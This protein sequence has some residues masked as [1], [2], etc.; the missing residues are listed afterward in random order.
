MQ[1]P[2]ESSVAG[3][4]MCAIHGVVVLAEKLGAFQL[5]Q[6]PE[7]NLR[8]IRILNLDG[9]DRHAVNATPGCGRRSVDA[10]LSAPGTESV[11]RCRRQV[12]NFG[13]GVPD[14]D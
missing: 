8:V 1:E 4:I 14:V 11:R 7:D 6:V 5:G 9:P 13:D 3:R 10:A 12:G 2:L